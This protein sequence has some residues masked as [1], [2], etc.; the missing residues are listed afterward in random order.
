MPG[1][2]P[3]V[4]FKI[5][6]EDD[7]VIV[8][9]KPAGL[10]T[11]TVPRERR[12]TAWA[13]LRE[14]VKLREPRARVGLIHRLD[15]DA[16]GLLVFSKNDRA[17]R[18]LKDQFFHHTVDRV[19]LAIV[20]GRLNPTSG[21]IESRLVEQTD[22]T[23]RSA[24]HGPGE[25]AISDYVV[26]RT[27]GELS[28][29]RVTLLTGRKHQIRVHLAGRGAPIVGDPLYS[30]TDSRTVGEKRATSPLSERSGISHPKSAS[31]LKRGRSSFSARGNA[32]E[33]ERLM[34]A[35]VELAFDHPRNGKRQ[36]ITI[37][38]PPPMKRLLK[39]PGD[40]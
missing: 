33:A 3:Q 39:Q 27:V 22:G 17:Y 23:V 9:D 34:L 11:S 19:Y 15:R 16:S 2:R 29:V 7:D 4:P 26:T 6:H 21:R 5:V 32:P 40:L 35:A 12:A 10:L 18:S 38:L 8:I 20:R 24:K 25:R 13:L 37:P 31:F 30:Q 36:R 28:L 14:Y 1:P